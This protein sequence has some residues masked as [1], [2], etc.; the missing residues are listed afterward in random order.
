MSAVA[1]GSLALA[2][3]VAAAAFPAPATLALEDAQTAVADVTQCAVGVGDRILEV[4]SDPELLKRGL[5]G[6][7]P[8]P[9]D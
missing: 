8:D 2:C 5:T 4:L 1:L 9:A 7:S 3:W 6:L